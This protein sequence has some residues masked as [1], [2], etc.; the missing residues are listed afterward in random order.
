MAGAST[1]TF[2][3]ATNNFSTTLSSSIGST[4]TTIPLTSVTNLPTTTGI[5]L[6]VD[7]VNSQG[8]LTPSLREYFKGVVSGNNIVLA[9]TSYRGLGNSSAQAHTNGAVVEMV[10]DSTW[11]NDIVNGILE[12]HVQLGY[13]GPLHD[14][15]GN[16]WIDQTATASAVNNLKVSNAATTNAPAI[17][18]EGSDTNIGLT[19]TSKGSGN[20]TLTAGSSGVVSTNSPTL[21]LN[22]NPVWQYLG[23]AQI[24]SNINTTSTSATL[25]TG[26]SVGVTIPTGATR[27]R[28]TLYGPNILQAPGTNGNVY[29]YSGPTYG[30]LTTQ[31]QYGVAY[32]GLQAP[33]VIFIDNSPVAGSI[34]YSGAYLTNNASDAI[35]VYAS[36]GG[37]AYILVECC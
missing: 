8:I 24:T 16:T 5:V 20:I 9:S 35:L 22:S 31:K 37:P 23:S 12:D 4:T 19:M 11:A 7:R 18:A 25:M 14:A 3:L 13:H 28:V 32:G 15:N 29:I 1:D 34:Y 10:P 21:A 17:A 36:S 2:S 6:V 30:A 27:V 33:P 26:L